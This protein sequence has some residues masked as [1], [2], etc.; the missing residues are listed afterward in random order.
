[1]HIQVIRYIVLQTDTYLDPVLFE[2]HVMDRIKNNE[3]EL[4]RLYDQQV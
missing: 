2:G 3:Y 4:D 1:M